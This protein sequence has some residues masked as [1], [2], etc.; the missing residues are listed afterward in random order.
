MT[1]SIKMLPAPRYLVKRS[2]ANIVKAYGNDLPD[3]RLANNEP[4]TRSSRSQQRKQ[5]EPAFS[6]KVRRKWT[7]AKSKVS[8]RLGLYTF[9]EPIPIGLYLDMVA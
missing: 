2:P 5:K 1:Q 6:A 7:E 9:L 8:R 4:K 3:R